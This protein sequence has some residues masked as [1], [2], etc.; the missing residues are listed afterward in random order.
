MKTAAL[1]CL[2]LFATVG[3]GQDL[4]AVAPPLDV[5][6]TIYDLCRVV[7]DETVATE[8]C[9]VQYDGGRHGD[10]SDRCND[11]Y[12]SIEVDAI[13]QGLILPPVPTG[14]ALAS[15]DPEDSF[16]VQ[17]GSGQPA[18][19]SIRPG[20]S[21]DPLERSPFLFRAEVWG[22]NATGSP[23]AT[24]LAVAYSDGPPV[25]FGANAGG[26]HTVRVV[27]IDGDVPDVDRSL[28]LVCHYMCMQNGAAV[29]G[30]RVNVSLPS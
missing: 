17:L 6:E 10:A 14:N 30:Y 22:P 21:W 15:L 27:P 29:M 2:S 28:P 5:E 25:S 3:A 11:P 24:R 26:T 4:I 1:I 23:C 18:V 20:A 8:L 19:L 13:V 9:T 12:P 16:A 7:V